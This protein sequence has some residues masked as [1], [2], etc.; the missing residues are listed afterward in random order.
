LAKLGPSAARRRF[1]PAA[2]SHNGQSSG[3]G[4]IVSE[5]QFR[6]WSRYVI[7]AVSTV[8]LI[9]GVVLL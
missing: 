5:T 6:T 9:Q 4:E 2:A 8:Y 3:A 7:G 1:T